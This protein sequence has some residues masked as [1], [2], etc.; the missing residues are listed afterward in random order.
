MVWVIWFFGVNSGCLLGGGIE[1]VKKF[2]WRICEGLVIEWW[3]EM[4]EKVIEGGEVRVM[5]FLFEGWLFFCGWKIVEGKVR[6]KVL[7]GGD[8]KR[9]WL[10]VGR[11]E[12]GVM[13]RRV[14][15]WVVRE[16]LW[17]KRSWVGGGGV[18]CK[19]GC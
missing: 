15:V 8:L 16:V 4:M 17:W 2:R 9:D 1:G 19:E 7:V 11:E 18:D 3:V 5:W 12:K 6:M 10:G 14:V 13:V